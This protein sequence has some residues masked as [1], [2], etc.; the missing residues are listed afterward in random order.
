[1]RRRAI[2]A[3]KT[4]QTIGN[5]EDVALIPE[6]VDPQ[7]ELSRNTVTQPFFVIIDEDT[8]L[9]GGVTRRN[10]DQ[11]PSVTDGAPPR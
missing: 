11:A 7:V 3:F 8:V 2:P 5:Y 4:A 1:M 6:D 10:G 9:A